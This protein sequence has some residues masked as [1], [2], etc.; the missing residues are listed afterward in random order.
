MLYN[1]KIMLR[2]LE[3]NFTYSSGAFHWFGYGTF[4]KSADFQRTVF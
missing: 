2:N 1:L 4:D 3:R